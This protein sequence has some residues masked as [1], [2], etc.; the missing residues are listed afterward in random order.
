MTNTLKVLWDVFDPVTIFLLL[1]LI[2]TAILVYGNA[3][4]RAVAARFVCYTVAISLL[5]VGLPF[6]NLLLFPLEQRFPKDEQPLPPSPAGILVLGGGIDAEMSHI[7][8]A[9]ELNASG[10]RVL[11]MLHLG[12]LYPEAPII[13]SGGPGD[14]RAQGRGDAEAL[15]YA[16]LVTNS[17][18]QRLL[19]EQ[20]SGNTH[21]NA[22]EA[23]R[24]I[25]GDLSATNA[26]W[27]LVTSA[28]HMPRAVG[29]FRSEGWVVHPYPVDF[30][31]GG[32]FKT[33]FLRWFRNL[34]DLKL[35][36]KEWAGLVIYHRLGWSDSAFP[37]PEVKDGQ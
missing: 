23:K 22:V 17:I 19:I 16:P 4:W 1:T 21:E 18:A 35:A 25:P 27:I 20:R 11:A 34:D 31:S 8:Q 12:Q 36:I 13:Y 30:R 29:A 32:Q 10:D 7:R 24:L 33:S 2:S 26:P 37:S 6:G 3:R 14:W 9:M 5:V 15:A 28:W